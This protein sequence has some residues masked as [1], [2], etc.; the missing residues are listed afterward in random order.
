MNGVGLL[1]MMTDQRSVLLQPRTFSIEKLPRHALYG[2]YHIQQEFPV[3]Q[4]TVLWNN[5]SCVA[6]APGGRTVGNILTSTYD[7]V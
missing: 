3:K 7:T 5:D 6:L 1:K 2:K 4:V